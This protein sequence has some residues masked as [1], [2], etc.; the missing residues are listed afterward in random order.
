M[1]KNSKRANVVSRM[2]TGC[3]LDENPAGIS[4]LKMA[5]CCSDLKRESMSY[6]SQKVGESIDVSDEGGLP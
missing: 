2:D 6:G 5:G 4:K 3:G 1:R